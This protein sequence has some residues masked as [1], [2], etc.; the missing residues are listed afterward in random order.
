VVLRVDGQTIAELGFVDAIS[1]LRGE[2]G[3]VVRLEV[4]RADGTTTTVDVVRRP[5]SF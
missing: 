1:R 2:E 4:R 5:I 3:T